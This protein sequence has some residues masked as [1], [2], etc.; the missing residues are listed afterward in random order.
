[1]TVEPIREKEKIKQLY[2]YLNG[3]NP[4]YGMIFKTGINTGLR[5]SDILSLKVSDIFI[6]GCKFR[7]HL[8]ISE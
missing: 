2:H 1:M 4:R 5:I 7:E 6:N 3:V 8:T